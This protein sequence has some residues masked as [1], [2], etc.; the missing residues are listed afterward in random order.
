MRK[1]TNVFSVT[2]LV[3]LLMFSALNTF[4][5]EK[6]NL[7]Q[8]TYTVDASLNCYV[9]AMG[10]VEFGQ[11]LLV[12]AQVDVDSNNE[13]TMTLNF[14]KSSVTIYNI[15][16][17]TFIDSAPSSEES[18]G[19]VKNGT[20]GFYDD[21]GVLQTDSVE[22]TLSDDTA[23]NPKNEEVN[24]VESM[25]FPVESI[26]DTYELTL[27][28]NSNVMGVQ[29]GSGGSSSYPA[30]LTV[31]WDNIKISVASAEDSRLETLPSETK[32]V[33]P[34]TEVVI[35]EE[36]K[37]NVVEKDGLN[38]HYADKEET[39]DNS[40]MQYSAYLNMEM[41]W[42]LIAVAGGIVV[43]GIIFI[44]SSKFKRK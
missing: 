1:I 39:N 18:K 22:F 35:Q 24:Y 31:D 17:D 28:V 7:S 40:S 12:S 8:G 25:T 32:N 44:V 29:F 33:E 9:N 16:C 26:K 10:G 27:Y 37:S 11:P 34:T 43:I 41:I 15:T 19:N 36:T 4:A 6:N 13:K 2:L 20:L 21:S 23:P 38:I 3:V 30:T 14:R 42:I 5:L